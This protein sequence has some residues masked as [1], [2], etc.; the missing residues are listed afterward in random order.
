MNLFNQ[1]LCRERIVQFDFP[2]GEKAVQIQKILSDWQHALKDNNLSGAK[3]KT[4]QGLFLI[5]F[6]EEVLGY[7]SQISN[8]GEWNLIQHPTSEVDA[9]E[10]DG[11]LGFF[12]T[13]EKITKAVIELKDARTLLD[14]KQSSREKGYTPIEQAY[15]YATKSDR[16]N[17]IIVSNFREIRLYNKNRTQDFFEK[18]EVLELH[19]EEQFKRFYYLLCKQ[20]LI[21]RSTISIID[22]LGNASIKEEENITKAFYA[23]YKN[24]RL[25]LFYHLI[26]Q[27]PHLERTLLLEKAQTIIDRL[28]FILFCEDT[29]SLLPRNLVKDTYEIGIR[30]RERSDQRVWREFKNLFM[31]ID[32]GRSDVD[33]EINRYNGGLFAHDTVLDTL[34]IRDVIWKQIISLNRYD[35][36]SELNVNILGHIFEQSISD[37]ET[38]KA[39]LTSEKIEKD[40]SRRKKEG[41]FYTPEFITK[42][43]VENVVK[44]FLTENPNAL[45][46]IKILDPACGSGAFLNQAHSYLTNEHRMRNEQKLLEKTGVQQLDFSDINLTESNR[47]ILLN[48][49]FGVD[50][51]R[52]S[53]EITK[54]S[55]WLKTARASEPLQDLD[56]NIKW[57]NSIVDDPTYALDAAFDWHNEFKA[58]L[59]SGGFDVVVGNPPYV[60]QELIKAIKP[61]LEKNYTVYTG[62]SDLYVY[63]FEKALSLLKENGFFAFIVSSGFLRA[64]YGK[65]LTHYLQQN[66]T[67]LELIEFGDLQIFEGATTYPVIITIQKKKPEAAQHPSLLKLV[68]LEAISNL[69][70]EMKRHG[71]AIEIHRDDT[72]WQLRTIEETDVLRKLKKDTSPLDNYVNRKI[73]RGI[74]TGFNEGFLIDTA[75]KN[76][77][78]KSD[79]SSE[80]VIKPILEGEDIKRYEY[81]SQT[82]W[83]IVIPAGWT[84]RNRQNTDAETY[85]Q[86]RYPAIYNHLKSAQASLASKAANPKRKGL[87][88][89]EDQGDYWWELR[90]CV[91]YNSFTSPKIIWGNLATRASFSL[92]TQGYYICA[93]ACFIP[94]HEKWLLALLNSSVSTFFLKHT[95]IERQGGFVE[96]KPQYIKQLPIPNVNDNVRALLTEKVEILF[97]LYVEQQELQKQALEVVRAEYK[98]AKV[99][100]KLGEFLHHSWNELFEELEKQKIK[101]DLTQKDQLNIWFRSK[102]NEAVRLNKLAEKINQEIDIHAYNLFNL[103]DAEIKLIES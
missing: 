103:N 87:Y 27:N 26:E 79:S 86:S 58:I 32:L 68:S 70:V 15:L 71:S 66:F 80:E 49:L 39:E 88:S 42:Y 51:N 43:L 78:Y 82:R 31:D 25:K 17:W 53:V 91:Y 85:V 5:K 62:V 102:Q 18:F 61:Y 40:V 94:T 36:E 29:G 45:E 38:L 10:P 67:I 69:D 6:F 60:R 12:T 75:T 57:G 55:L 28:I 73:F 4:I 84:N 7:S 59:D 23:D 99:T 35:F 8:K 63:F 98:V 30:S 76:T 37:I 77:L 81:N 1:K 21:S 96:Q 92:D 22:D 97:T 74:I 46:T 64:D 34:V 3:E 20:N 13:G 16:C 89:R 101:I 65:K 24:A 9:Q 47:S 48:N 100:Q 33:P 56:R 90:P 50:L 93:P 54:L 95:A 52:E 83:G 14:K 2:I 44:R 72:T 41:I 11:S 19:K